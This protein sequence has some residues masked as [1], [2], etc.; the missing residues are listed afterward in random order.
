[1]TSMHDDEDEESSFEEQLS[2]D[3][4]SF[5]SSGEEEEEEEEERPEASTSS[6][7]DEE[8]EK[9]KQVGRYVPPSQRG[10]SRWRRTPS[11]AGGGTASCVDSLLAS[12]LRSVPVPSNTLAYRARTGGLFSFGMYR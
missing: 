2:D 4:A 5:H 1:M 10:F 3:F 8:K 7:D 12:R 6:S 11:N 9:V